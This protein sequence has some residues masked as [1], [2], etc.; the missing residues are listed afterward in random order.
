MGIISGALG[1]LAQG[2]GNIALAGINQE[3][4]SKRDAERA[5]IEMRAQQQLAEFKL[6]REQQAKDAERAKIGGIVKSAS[7]SGRAAALD[8]GPNTDEALSQA[9][10]KRASQALAEG[11]YMAEAKILGDMDYKEGLLQAKAESLARQEKSDAALH[12]LRTKELALRGILAESKALVD[13]ARAAKL[14]GD[15]G[16]ST[17]ASEAIRKEIDS[18]YGDEMK[19]LTK[20]KGDPQY[21]ADPEY[22]ASVDRDIKGLRAKMNTVSSVAKGSGLSVADADTLV[23]GLADGSTPLRVQGDQVA[24][25]LGNGKGY[26]VPAPLRE[27]ALKN[28]KKPGSG[29]GGNGG[30]GGKEETPRILPAPDQVSKR[31]AEIESM[32]RLSGTDTGRRQGIINAR[33]EEATAGFDSMLRSLS[34]SGERKRAMMWFDDHMQDLS[35]AQKKQYRDTKKQLGIL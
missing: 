29:A 27:L 15:G 26:P 5:E 18:L 10:S 19:E 3:F 32:N 25:D 28:A 16:D 7:E 13:G 34:D 11:G 12:E 17:K 35:N 20:L 9:G 2:V 33:T 30:N 14:S 22:K 1:G 4:Q 8:L 24:F 21:R 31:D 23:S 6:Q